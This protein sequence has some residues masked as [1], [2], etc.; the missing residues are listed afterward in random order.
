MRDETPFLE[1]L[2]RVYLLALGVC[3]SLQGAIRDKLLHSWSG[4]EVN[5]IF[6]VVVRTLGTVFVKEVSLKLNIVLPGLGPLRQMF[7]KERLQDLIRRYSLLL[8]LPGHL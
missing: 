5:S 4:R 2:R 3:D 8:I 1:G 7:V 6:V